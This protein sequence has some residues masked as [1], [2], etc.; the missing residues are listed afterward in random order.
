MQFNQPR[1]FPGLTPKRAQ[2]GHVEFENCTIQKKAKALQPVPFSL[3]PISPELCQQ[4]IH[5]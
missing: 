4:I 2:R 5:F 1:F 3:D